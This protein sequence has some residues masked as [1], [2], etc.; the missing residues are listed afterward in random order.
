MA[1]EEEN[2]GFVGPQVTESMKRALGI[3]K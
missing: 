1:K 3:G 2:V